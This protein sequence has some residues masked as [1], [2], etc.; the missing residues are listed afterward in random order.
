MAKFG[1]KFVNISESE[2]GWV[3]NFFNHNYLIINKLH[4]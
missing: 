4:K 2:G 1:G 3:F